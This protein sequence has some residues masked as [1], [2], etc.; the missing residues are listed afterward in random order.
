MVVELNEL[1]ELKIRLLLDS[2][3]VILPMP[4][5]ETMKRNFASQVGN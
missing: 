3:V 2:V 1:T 4:T 5:M